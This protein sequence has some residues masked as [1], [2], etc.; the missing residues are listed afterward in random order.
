MKTPGPIVLAVSVLALANVSTAA[1]EFHGAAGWTRKIADQTHGG[2]LKDDSHGDEH[3]GPASAHAA[4]SSLPEPAIGDDFLAMG[5]EA[6]AAA[7]GLSASSVLHLASHHDYGN[8]AVGF[9][10]S[11]GAGA[12]MTIDDL[13]FTGP[14]GATSVPTSVNVYV[15]GLLSERKQ[16]CCSGGATAVVS[17]TI[18]GRPVRGFSVV[19]DPVGPQVY[20]PGV[21]VTLQTA[22][23][24]PNITTKTAAFAGT[25]ASGSTVVPLGSSVALM[26]GLSTH[27]DL[28]GGAGPGQS[29]FDAK[30]TGDASHTVRLPLAGPIFNLPDGYSVSSASGLIVGNQLG[31]LATGSTTTSTIVGA[32]TTTTLIPG[33]GCA[34]LDGIAGVDCTCRAGVSAVCP[35]V[36]VPSSVTTPFAQACS[37]ADAAAAASGKKATRLFRKAVKKVDK[38]GRAIG[39]PKVA[40][41]LSSA[42][43][44]AL[45]TLFGSL[46]AEIDGL[47]APR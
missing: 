37:T 30:F 12:T 41:K 3:Y 34:V 47:R 21:D 5:G 1:T 2:Y 26:I 38:L 13:L 39:K 46:R 33:R 31:T 27:E 42:C 19:S 35:D 20:P 23:Q 8:E 10:L 17:V 11:S 7:S 14:P 16:L 40:K 36:T 18:A 28:L 32:T 24:D 29:Q 22:H 9:E 44:A 25:F 6:N 15:N 43:A 45:K 4:E